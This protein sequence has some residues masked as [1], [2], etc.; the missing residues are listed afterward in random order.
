MFN[1]WE[2]IILIICCLVSFRIMRAIL[3]WLLRLDSTKRIHLR[4]KGKAYH[5]D[6]I[7]SLIHTFCGTEARIGIDKAGRAVKYCWRCEYIFGAS[8]IDPDPD[9]GEPVSEDAD[10]SV[11]K[12]IA[13]S[14]RRKAA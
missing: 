1:F 7:S 10:T 3:N 4:D 11:R 12:V 14:D 2:F 6:G 5:G 9:D 8:N 13:I